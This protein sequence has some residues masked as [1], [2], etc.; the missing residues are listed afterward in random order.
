[1]LNVLAFDKVPDYLAKT[2]SDF[3]QYWAEY[4][5]LA[6]PSIRNYTDAL[7][8]AED[9]G[10]SEESEDISN[11]IMEIHMLFIYLF[12]MREEYDQR[13][14]SIEQLWEKYEVPKVVDYF[15]SL[16]ISI[17]QLLDIFELT[18]YELGIGTMEIGNNF[19]V[20]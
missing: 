20:L 4:Y 14:I 1:M 19:E 6:G 2:G 8:I 18:T 15:M 9:E 10:V 13:D 5:S 7:A 11:I 17:Y 12:V 3:S 16:G